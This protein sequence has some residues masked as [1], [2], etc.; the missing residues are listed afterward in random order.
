MSEDRPIISRYIL[1]DIRNKLLSKVKDDPEAYSLLNNIIDIYTKY[2][3][4]GVKQYI[5]KIISEG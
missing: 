3:V 4:R 1:E 5:N 2:G